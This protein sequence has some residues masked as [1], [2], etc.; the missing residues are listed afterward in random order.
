MVAAVTAFRPASTVVPVGGEPVIAMYGPMLG[1]LITNPMYLED[2]GILTAEVLYVDLSG[3]AAL[4]ETATTFPLQPGQTFLVPAGFSGNVSVNAVTGGH[5]FSGVLWQ[6]A[7]QPPTPQ[8]GTFPPS[9]PTTLVSTIP[10]YLYKEYVDDDDLQAFVSAYN[11]LAQIFVTWFAEGLLPVY[12]SDTIAGALL[13]WVGTGLYGIPRPSLSSGRSRVIGPF[14]TYGFNTLPLNRRRTIGP[15]DVTI[16]TDDIY[17]RV[18]TWNFYKGDGNV[19]NVRWLKRRI[20]RFLIGENGSAPNIDNTQDISVVFGDGVIS[21]SINAGTRHITGG[22]LFNRFGFNRLPMNSLS[23]RFVP[24]TNPFPFESVLKEAMDAGVL[25]VP[26]QY[27]F[28]VT[29]S[30]G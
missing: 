3:P 21:I 25:T 16:A 9:G 28:I 15:S 24:G 2:L 23:T 8:P 6:P 13:D 1:G 29:T 26:F 7:V 20:M 27:Q 17:K 14:N 19:F 18:L 22:S 11:E 12:T 4:Q 10:S 30:G 5:K